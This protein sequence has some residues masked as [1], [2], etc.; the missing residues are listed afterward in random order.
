MG[1]CNPKFPQ[2]GQGLVPTISPDLEHVNDRV[3]SVDSR[4]IWRY[5]VLCHIYARRA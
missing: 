2:A 5:V 1:F 4:R 3:E